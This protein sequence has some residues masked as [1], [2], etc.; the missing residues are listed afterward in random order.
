VPDRHGFDH[1]PDW[2][3]VELRC[4]DCGEGGPAWEWPEARRRRHHAAHER[5]RRAELARR[6]AAR[7]REATARLRLVNRLRREA[8]A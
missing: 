1:L 5:E 3:D 2:G 8:R 6:E 4:V 7:R